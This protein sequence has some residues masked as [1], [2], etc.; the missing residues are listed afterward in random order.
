MILQHDDL[1]KNISSC[2]ILPHIIKYFKTFDLHNNLK[3]KLKSLQSFFFFFYFFFK[4]IL[5]LFLSSLVVFLW[6]TT[7]IKHHS[8]CQLRNYSFKKQERWICCDESFFIYTYFYRVISSLLGLLAG[9]SGIRA[10]WAIEIKSRF[11]AVK[12]P[13]FGWTSC[14]SDPYAPLA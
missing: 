9:P 14:F 13:S 2:Q 4:N 1:D 6:N 11:E 10:G 12:A 5:S 3:I 7:N 8:T